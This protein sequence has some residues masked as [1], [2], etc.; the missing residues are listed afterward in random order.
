[1][2]QTTVCSGLKV[3]DKPRLRKHV[4]IL[5]HPQIMVTSYLDVA[6]FVVVCNEGV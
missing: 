1:M 5:R 4:L 6:Y 2:G 3:V